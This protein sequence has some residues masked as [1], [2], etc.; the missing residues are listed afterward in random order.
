MSAISNEESE[1]DKKRKLDEAMLLLDL[2][3]IDSELLRA[4]QVLCSTKTIRTCN[5]CSATTTPMWRHGPPE[6]PDLCNK[7]FILIKCGVK[8]MRGRLI[9]NSRNSK[10]RK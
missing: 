6:Y 10:P 7:V 5:Y 9:V 3:T 4:A 2:P 8:W 1:I